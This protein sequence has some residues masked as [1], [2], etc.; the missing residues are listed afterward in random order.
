MSTSTL[1]RW[2]LRHI[3]HPQVL[4]FLLPSGAPTQVSPVTLTARRTLPTRSVV[5][6]RRCSASPVR[7]QDAPASAAP[8]GAQGALN[9]AQRVKVYRDPADHHRTVLCGTMAEVCDT[10]DRLVAAQA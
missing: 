8:G 10:L 2:M 3:T 1:R 9:A 5:V 6:T 4:S 7:V